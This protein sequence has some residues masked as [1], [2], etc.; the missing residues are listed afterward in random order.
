MENT[1]DDHTGGHFFDSFL[2]EPGILD[3]RC[4]I[5]LG[6][7]LVRAAAASHGGTVLVEQTSAATKIT[8]SLLISQ[9]T[10]STVSSP[11]LRV[12]YAGERDH[13]LLELSDA[14]PA[15]AYKNI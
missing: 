8:L 13:R 2:R 15:D 5:G 3:G 6:M 11:V 4:G 9:Q 10:E 14:L 7:V 12:D 1:A